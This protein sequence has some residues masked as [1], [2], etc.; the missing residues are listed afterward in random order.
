M[1]FADEAPA[2]QIIRNESKP[3]HELVA[4]KELSSYSR[5]TR[6]KYVRRGARDGSVLFREPLPCIRTGIADTCLCLSPAQLRRVHDPVLQD[7][8]RADTARPKAGR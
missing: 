5:F 2:N 1:H 7:G 4:E 3:A 6:N 8:R